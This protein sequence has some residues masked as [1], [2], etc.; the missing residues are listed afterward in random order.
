MGREE[1]LHVCVGMITLGLR[2]LCCWVMLIL[3]STLFLAHKISAYSCHILD[4]QLR[5]TAFFSL[6]H[7]C[8]KYPAGQKHREFG[9]FP[10]GAESVESQSVLT[11]ASEGG[12]ML[13]GAKNALGRISEK[14][15]LL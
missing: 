10:R 12:Q 5:N 8:L 15:L 13:E 14:Y 4:K 6:L 3:L 7:F 9:S 11:P 1:R 2:A